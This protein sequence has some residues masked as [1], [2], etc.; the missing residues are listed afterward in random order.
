MTIYDNPQSYKDEVSEFI[1]DCVYAVES[2]SF[3]DLTLWQK[4]HEKV[5]WEQICSGYGP[6]IG[7]LGDRPVCVSIHVNIINGHRVL[8]YN[9]CS[10]V[11]DHVMVEAWVKERIKNKKLTDAGNFHL[12]IHYIDDLNKGIK[13]D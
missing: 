4:Y 13:N 12:V 1:K 9:A 6:T 10:Q 2:N 8:F 7:M 11:V 3:E 5:K